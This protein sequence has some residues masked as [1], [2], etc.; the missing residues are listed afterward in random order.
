MVTRKTLNGKPQAENPHVIS[1]MTT[2]IT[3][4]V[5][6]A[7]MS[8]HAETYYHKGAD[9]YGASSFNQAKVSNSVGWSTSP[10]GSIVSS[11]ADWAGSDFIVSGSANSIRIPATDADIT[12][13]GKSLAVNDSTIAFKRANGSTALTRNVTIADFRFTGTGGILAHG[14]SKSD[15]G[16]QATV[17][18]IKGGITIADGA[19]MTLDQSFNSNNDTREFVVDSAVSGGETS[20][21]AFRI[22]YSSGISNGTAPVTFNSLADF[23]GT[24]KVDSAT[25][26]PNFNLTVNGTFNGTVTSL[27]QNAQW[28]RFDFDGLPAG[29]GVRIKGTS[30]GAA[31]AR[32]R[33]HSA[34]ADFTTPGLVVATFEDVSSIGV[35]ENVG[36][37]VQYSTSLDGTYSPVLLKAQT[38][39]VGQVTLV[40]TENTY[41]KTGS[42]T[43]YNSS[44]PTSST[45]SSGWSKMPGGTAVTVLAGD[46][47]ASDFIV[48]G[49]N[50][51][52]ICDS[53]TFGG[54]SLKI[55]GPGNG[56]SSQV[57]LKTNGDIGNTTA[58]ATIGNLI[59]SGG[60]VYLASNEAYFKIAGNVQIEAGRSFGIMPVNAENGYALR[61]IEIVA[62]VAG[63]A[64]TTIDLFKT[65]GTGTKTIAGDM[66]VVFD[67]L[68]NFEGVFNDKLSAS[69]ASEN[70]VGDASYIHFAGKFGGRIGTMNANA[71]KFIVNY[72]G[73]P[74]GKGL[75]AAT[76]SIPAKFNSG[77]V[78]YSSDVSKFMTDGTVLA[79]FPAGTV[80]DPA[81][82]V[83]EYA[84][85]FAGERFAMPPC[86]T[87]SGANGEVCLVI[88][89]AAPSYAKMVKNAQTDEYEWHFYL[90][91][92]NGA[93][94]D[95]IT[96]TCGKTVPDNSMVVL[97]ASREEFAAIS[98][99]P[100]T[101]REYQLTAFTCTEDSDFSSVAFAYSIVAAQGLTIDPA[102]HRVTVRAALANMIST[103]TSGTAG[104]EFCVNVASGSE[105]LD[106]PVIS[107][108]VK[109]VKTGAGTLYCAK[110]GQTYTGGNKVEAGLL[111]APTPPADEREVIPAGDINQGENRL[112][113]TTTLYKADQHYFGAEGNSITVESGAGFD[114][115]SNYGYHIYDIVLNG[116]TLWNVQYSSASLHQSAAGDGVGFR[117]TDD[118]A[119]RFRSDILISGGDPINLGGHRLSIYCAIGSKY[120]HLKN[121]ITNGTV[122]LV[123]GDAAYNRTPDT[124]TGLRIAAAVDA[125]DRFTLEDGTG[126]MVTNAF[127]ISNYTAKLPALY[128]WI[129]LYTGQ[130]QM[131]V[132]G[133]FRPEQRY[134]PGCT[135][136]A[137]STVDLRAWNFASWGAVKSLATE[138][139]NGGNI[140][141]AGNVTIDMS[142]RSDLRELGE[143][144]SESGVKKGTYLFKWGE[145]EGAD[146]PVGRIFRLDETTSQRYHFIYDNVG[147]RFIKT[148][149]LIIYVR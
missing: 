102:G 13:A 37:N 145:E 29:K 100:G 98:A 135:M 48:S 71:A 27:P 134:F 6:L 30:P 12:F 75:R 69:T 58:V 147:L 67:D 76:T 122:E 103:V 130:A 60:A 90:A 43:G 46:I 99:N 141:F 104:S 113:T 139:Y 74:A 117:L 65:A 55:V 34:T 25:T 124:G 3:A 5:A 32:L 70:L 36:W 119:M 28:A 63:G 97:F 116:G 109:L 49:G 1:R 15:H 10:N 112:R 106:G 40:T 31:V 56:S 61:R 66:E 79:T 19:A 54:A 39:A 21:I 143:A 53:M 87:E 131:T 20:A 33:L 7:T 17:F 80:V 123:K 64:N 86:R 62:P 23:Y 89:I 129:S 95:D 83:F 85:S 125:S 45:L 114:I 14:E 81:A 105:T 24:L 22:V 78:F 16:S 11:I 127:T 8:I 149:G 93:L 138:S 121:S 118:S 126:L 51:L 132:T 108:T 4:L 96:A 94:G 42:D 128:G 110:A 2:A 107:G 26:T 50:V 18:C 133:T 77:T 101:A 120:I 92:D 148:K 44:L 142:G 38:N 35:V 146:R 136:A 82:F 68:E 84:S 91:G 144:E 41:Y 9:G 140:D 111:S 73:L 52:R 137:G 47:A 59:F 57:V 72:D 88:D 115:N